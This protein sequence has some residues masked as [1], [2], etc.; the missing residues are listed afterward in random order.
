MDEKYL[1]KV[2]SVIWT[3]SYGVL[4]G[5]Q[6]ISDFTAEPCIVNSWGRII[7]ED[8]NLISLA[9]NYSLET[10]N[11]PLQANGIIVIPKVCISS[12]SVI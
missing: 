4:P 3:D 7:Y 6:D 5:W 2:V 8:S 1:D 11:S 10:N 9:H 12:I